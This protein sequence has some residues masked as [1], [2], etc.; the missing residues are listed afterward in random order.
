[1]RRHEAAGGLIPC[2][3]RY[4]YSSRPWQMKNFAAAAPAAAAHMLQNGP[5][6]DPLGSVL[7]SFGAYGG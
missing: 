1:M 4:M 7:R 5:V 2:W 3:L 6:Q